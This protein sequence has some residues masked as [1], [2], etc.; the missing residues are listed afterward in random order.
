MDWSGIIANTNLI[1]AIGSVGTFLTFLT[2]LY[3]IY[4]ADRKI[5]IE[6]KSKI[7]YTLYRDVKSLIDKCEDYREYPIFLESLWGIEAPGILYKD[8]QEVNTR[9]KSYHYE[10]QAT[11][12]R[13]KGKY[14]L[15]YFQISVLR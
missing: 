6:T 2:M 5:R 14:Y 1:N 10:L 13:I 7:Y 15:H 3:F 4:I 11:K 12:E 8:V 9:L